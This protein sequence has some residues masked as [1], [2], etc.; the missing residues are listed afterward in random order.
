MSAASPPPSN[1]LT[2]KD[3]E[4]LIARVGTSHA[5]EALA[6]PS[7]M[8]AALASL[9]RSHPTFYARDGDMACS[10]LISSFLF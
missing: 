9:A 10:N 1:A 5:L 3:Y 4:R 8:L 6:G 2:N 7:R